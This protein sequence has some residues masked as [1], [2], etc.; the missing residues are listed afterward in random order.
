MSG[1]GGTRA[2]QKSERAKPPVVQGA[3]RQGA[4]TDN[5]DDRKP[6]RLTQAERSATMR[7]KLL[8]AATKHLAEVGYA[9]FKVESVAQEASVTRGAIHHQ[10]G[11]R[12]ALLGALVNDLGMELLALAASVTF[13]SPEERLDAAIDHSWAIIGSRHFIA[14]LQI[15]IGMQSD[16]DLHRQIIKQVTAFEVQLDEAW[17]EMLRDAVTPD[18]AKA[19]RHVM[20]A[21]LRGLTIRSIYHGQILA[22]ETELQLLRE[23]AQNFLGPG[24]VKPLARPA[25]H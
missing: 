15:L 20:T 1:S 3:A 17:S 22:S 12:G 18:R 13:G 5:P 16:D 14:V 8:D 23:M 10:F 19:I 7:R 21:A 6:R 2:P 24:P 25:S 4:S 11:S 9:A